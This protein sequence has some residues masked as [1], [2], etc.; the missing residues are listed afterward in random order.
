[1]LRIIGEQFREPDAS[2]LLGMSRGVFY[3]ILLGAAGIAIVVAAQRRAGRA[4]QAN[5]T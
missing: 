3:S 5:S 1:M 2:L 4:S